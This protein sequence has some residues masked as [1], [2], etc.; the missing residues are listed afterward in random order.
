MKMSKHIVK[1]TMMIFYDINVKTSCFVGSIMMNSIKR[2]KVP[3]P[4]SIP[5]NL[6]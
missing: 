5:S 1:I 4:G 2:Y 3:G 6:S